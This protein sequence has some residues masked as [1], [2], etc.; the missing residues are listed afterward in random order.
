MTKWH[1]ATKFLLLGRSRGADTCCGVAGTGRRPAG[2]GQRRRARSPPSRRSIRRDRPTPARRAFVLPPLEQLTAVVE[3]PLFSPTRRMPVQVARDEAPTASGRARR[4]RP[5][6]DLPSRSCGS[7][8]PRARTA[9]RRHWSPSPRTTKVG[10][11]APGDRVGEWQVLSVE[12]D[13]LVLGLGDEQRK[14]EIFGA[15]RGLRHG[16]QPVPPASDPSG[17]GWCQ[18]SLP[19]S[20]PTF[21]P[22]A[23]TFRP[24]APRGVT[25]PRESRPRATLWCRQLVRLGREHVA[26]RERVA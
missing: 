20:P 18:N 16:P 25:S 14:F 13:Q 1:P 26:G 17:T 19:T 15:G 22:V 24:V 5:R 12:R 10:R 3:R 9:W 4:S 2:R 7:S 6:L 23:P 8:E 21:R 11:L